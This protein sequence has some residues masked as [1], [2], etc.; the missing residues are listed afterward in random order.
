VEEKQNSQEGELASQQTG[1]SILSF[2]Q[3]LLF[4]LVPVCCAGAIFY[5]CALGRG[6]SFEL[7][8]MVFFLN[9]FTLVP[10]II[11]I[12]ILNRYKDRHK[13][14]RVVRLALVYWTVFLL[15]SAIAV[16]AGPIAARR[17]VK[18]TLRAG[19]KLAVQLEEYREKHGSYPKSLQELHEA[20]FTFDRALSGKLI[21][22][23]EKDEAEY[24]LMFPDPGG[25]LDLW[26]YDSRVGKWQYTD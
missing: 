14:V 10:A 24:R 11:S 21:Y 2:R 26:I 17:N 9:F 7:F 16:F 5:F 4:L 1:E 19:E 3:F 12:S 18:A 13:A 6:Y 20:G 23:A 22:L 8:L 25:S 15:L